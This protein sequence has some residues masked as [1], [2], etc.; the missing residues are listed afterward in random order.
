MEHGTHFKWATPTNKL[1]LRIA[2]G[3]MKDELIYD[4]P[5]SVYLADK[6]HLNS[7][8]CVDLLESPKDYIYNLLGLNKK[9]DAEEP[10]YFRFGRAVHMAVLEPAKFR[11]SYVIEPIFEGKTKQG[12]LTTNPNCDEVRAL[13]A[14]WQASLPMDALILKEKEMDMLLEMIDCVVENPQTANIFRNGK[15]EVTGRFTHPKYNIRCKIRP[16]YIT[17][18]PDGKYYYFDLKT[19]RDASPGL[20]ATEAA[21][22]KYVVKMAFYHD[23][24]TTIMGRP[25]EAGAL[26][27]V[28]KS[29]PS[30]TDICWLNDDDI[31]DGRRQ[32]EYA[33][34]CLIRSMD[35]NDWPRQKTHGQML[36][37]PAW[38]K[39][40]PLPEFSWRNAEKTGENGG[41]KEGNHEGEG[42]KDSDQRSLQQG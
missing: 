3:E 26:L 7:G 9:E 37:M 32:Y 11:D 1:P 18:M 17:V 2:P 33:I 15:P 20:F 28:Q 36:S 42:A 21:R 22:L 25:P 30:K 27:P 31:A 34:E 40:E 6:Q 10:D 19:T 38:S 24:L 41:T 39:S 35:T 14:D 12:K 13:K 23:G 29:I 8:G 5:F 16:D 4:E